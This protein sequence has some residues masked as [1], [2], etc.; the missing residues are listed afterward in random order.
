MEPAGLATADP[1]SL[2]WGA[3]PQG[4]GKHLVRWGFTPKGPIKRA[5]EQRP[6]N[7]G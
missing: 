2:W 6:D 1:G 5:Y 7:V 3:H 4:V